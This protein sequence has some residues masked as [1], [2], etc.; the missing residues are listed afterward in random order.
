M[1]IDLPSLT[2]TLITGT[3]GYIFVILLLRISGK[4]TLSKWNSFD[5]VITITFGS[6]LS[7]IILSKEATP[8]FQAMVAFGLL[9]LYQFIITWVAARS[10]IIHFS[11]A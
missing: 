9:I 1:F 8:F 3:L 7:A 10:S 11:R 4:R 6:I 5:F 2:Y